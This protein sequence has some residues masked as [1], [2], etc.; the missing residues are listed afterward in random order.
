MSYFSFKKFKVE[1]D[2]SSMKVGT[3]AVLLGAWCDISDA[4]NILEIGCGCGV[5]SLIVAQRTMSTNIIGIDMDKDSVVEANINFQ[6]SPF[7]AKL[8]AVHCDLYDY[9]PHIKFNCILSNPPYFTEETLSPSLRRSLARNSKSLPFSDLVKHAKRMM[10][11]K[12]SLQVIIPF[13]EIDN[14]ISETNKQGLTLVRRANIVTKKGKTPKRVLLHFVNFVVEDPV[15]NET[16]VL[17]DHN[18]ERSENYKKLTKDL[19]I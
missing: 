3:D 13:S 17:S 12:A 10:S 19:Y 18:N 8:K 5:I 4:T 1:H 16:L 14:F 2:N 9:Q 6:Q 11:D 7:S 15:K